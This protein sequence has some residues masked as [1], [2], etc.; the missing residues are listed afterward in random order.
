MFRNIIEEARIRET[1]MGS[2]QDSESENKLLTICYGS[3]DMVNVMFINF[4]SIDGDVD[5]V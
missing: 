5:K 3:V 2:S 1:V 4:A